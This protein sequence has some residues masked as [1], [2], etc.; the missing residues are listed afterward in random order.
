MTFPCWPRRNIPSHLGALPLMGTQ[1][2]V[3]IVS[4]TV[5]FAAARYEVVRLAHCQTACYTVDT[6]NAAISELFVY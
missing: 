4:A 6:G 3:C 5:E 2:C 1:Y